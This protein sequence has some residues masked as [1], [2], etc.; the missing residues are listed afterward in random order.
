MAEGKPR[1][2]VKAW[3]MSQAGDPHTICPRLSAH[4]PAGEKGAG[5]LLERNSDC[6]SSPTS[7]LPRVGG[8]CR[9][10]V[11]FSGHG[12]KAISHTHLPGSGEDEGKCLGGSG[13]T[14]APITVKGALT[15]SECPPRHSGEKQDSGVPH[16]LPKEPCLICTPLI[17]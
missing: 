4:Q 12:T 1:P 11:T 9:F 10:W 8:G 2:E 16:E 5:G 7:S 14:A 3:A 13:L 17:C 6:C 15:S